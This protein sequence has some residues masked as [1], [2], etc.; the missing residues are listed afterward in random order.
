M[1]NV[2]FVSNILALV[3][4]AESILAAFL[5]FRSLKY[6]RKPSKV[7]MAMSG[8]VFVISGIVSLMFLTSVVDPATPAAFWISRPLL[9]LLVGV[10][11]WIMLAMEQQ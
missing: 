10:P 8:F 3:M 11:S 5:A 4:L 9:L 6:V 2:F 7:P 1:D